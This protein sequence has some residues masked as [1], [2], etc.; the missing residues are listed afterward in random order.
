MTKGFDFRWGVPALDDPLRFAVVYEFMLDHYA[1]VITRAEFLCIIH[2][3]RYHYNS[4]KGKSRPSL[5]T[6]AKQMGYGHK[7]SV[8]RLVQSL[9]HK[10]MLTVDRRQGLTSI[11]NA[12]PFTQSMLALEGITLGGDTFQCDGVSHPVVPEEENKKR[13]KEEGI[14]T[15][16]SLEAH[17]DS[18]KNKSEA[19]ASKGYKPAVA[20]PHKDP[21]EVEELAR[22]LAPP[23]DLVWGY[24]KATNK[25]LLRAARELIKRCK[26][27]D[28]DDVL[29]ALDT[30]LE[31][32]GDWARESIEAPMGL[33]SLVARTFQRMQARRTRQ[34]ASRDEWADAA[35]LSQQALADRQAMA[36]EREVG[37]HGAWSQVLGELA[38]Q[39]TRPTF[40]AWFKDTQLLSQEDG[41]MVVGV[42]N[43]YAKDWIENRMM[44]LIMRVLVGFGIDSVAFKVMT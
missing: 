29:E 33:V 8:S 32:N 19:L 4:R 26:G 44:S 23:I 16:D 13:N 7:N 14:I 20:D 37:D 12:A 25:S 39:M 22:Q 17:P 10:G 6:I 18:I 43:P 41:A 27:G 2:L 9:E 5:N 3:A 42:K 24:D 31:K 11:Y 1:E 15:F 36:T 35:E 40:D 38:L 34:A 30:Y 28:I 21:P